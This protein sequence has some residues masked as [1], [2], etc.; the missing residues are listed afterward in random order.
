MRHARR[1]TLIA[2]ALGCALAF[3]PLTATVCANDEPPPLAVAH[4]TPRPA[5]T[6]TVAVHARAHADTP[7]DTTGASAPPRKRGNA[8]LRALGAPFRALG[9]L[10]GGRKK[11]SATAKRTQPSAAPQTQVAHVNVIPAP[12][13]EKALPAPTA[14]EQAA[15]EQP[16]VPEAISPPAP[17]AAAPNAR[18]VVPAGPDLIAPGHAPTF[19]ATPE[20][21]P[22]FAPAPAPPGVFTP[23]VE[24]VPLDPLSQG[25]ALLERG[26]IGE[27]IAQLSVAAVT[28]PD[29]LTAN[30]MLGLAYDRMGWHD[31]AQQAYERALI[32]A[33]NDGPTL[34]NLGYSLYLSDRYTDALKRLK[35]AA[36]LDPANR[37]IVNNLALVYGRL[38]KYDDAYK[39]FARAGGEFY[40]RTQVGALLEAD[41]RDRDA[42]HHYEAARR[43]MPADAEVLRHL[44]NLYLRTG[45][46]GKAEDARRQLNKPDDKRADGSS[47]SS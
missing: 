36:K 15:A 10:F 8:F 17:V 5:G 6:T 12:T 13:P 19:T 38:K 21:P 16:G 39:Q 28:G 37:Q 9:R 34:N 2:P 33:P 35:A 47:T 26:F 24:N 42:L 32:A 18:P 3:N 27:A 4:V 40:A 31:Q 30:N 23:L 29:L 22:T 7:P 20:P 46:P 14:A 41:G 11:N 44:I 1:F 43:L 45:Q 25:R